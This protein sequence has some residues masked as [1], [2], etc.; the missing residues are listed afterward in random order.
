[1]D[2]YGFDE[3]IL[4]TVGVGQMD[5][6][7]RTVV[8]TVVLV[9]TPAT[10]DQIQAM[11]AGVLEA[12]DVYV[13]NKADLPRAEK[14]AA[15]LRSIAKPR[16]HPH[17]SWTPPVILVS[18]LNP[19]SV[20]ALDRAIDGHSAWIQANRDPDDTVRARKEYHVRSLVLRRVSEVLARTSA[21]ASGTS[22]GE[23]Y[24]RVLASLS[25]VAQSSEGQ[26]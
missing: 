19:S 3:V 2:T 15:E 17:A 12:A 10:G 5:H 1:M 26:S 7:L 9:T 21:A 22:V 6:G 16:G 18:A 25:S 14:I 4:E 20:L 23:L 8:D 11:K 13:V 24:D